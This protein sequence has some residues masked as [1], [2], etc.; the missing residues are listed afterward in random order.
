MQKIQNLASSPYL[1]ITT[2]FGTAKVSLDQQSSW[3][4]GRG[5]D[6]DIA[7]PDKS[8]SRYHALLQLLGDNFTL[9]DLGSRNGSFVNSQRVI[10]PTA[11][12]PGDRI[13]IGNTYID[14]F[15]PQHQPNQFEDSTTSTAK[16]EMLHQRQLITVLVIDIRNFTRL[17]QQLDEN[18][19]SQMIG[20]WFNQAG[21][22]VSSY[23]S[24][25]NKYIGD[26]VM[27][28][29][30]H[31]PELNNNCIN[32]S[33]SQSSS[34]QMLQIFSALRELFIMSNSLNRKFQLPFTLRVGAGINTGYAMVGQMG[35]SGTDYT[36]L[37]DTVNAA[38]RLESV[39][40][41]IN[42][43][44][45]LGQKTYESMPNAHLLLPFKQH[46]VNLKGY[47]KR[48]STYAGNLIDLEHYL[49][50]MNL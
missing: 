17:S 21:Q 5:K 20:S 26:A 9:I 43:D 30:I 41:E 39:T 40:K 15:Y 47:D 10:V 46:L 6:N 50:N 35:T 27:S 29:W 8:T 36:A 7:L 1:L 45:A 42:V 13:S 31:N 14:F 18:I 49:K 25:V 44:I 48:I 12:K 11:L 37:G 22:I 38:F 19:L 34:Q 2:P 24:A 16:T 33:L 3:K 23:G 32:Q 4:I 28:I